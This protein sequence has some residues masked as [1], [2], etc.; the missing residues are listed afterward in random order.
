MSWQSYESQYCLPFTHTH[1]RYIKCHF[2]ERT[3]FCI[4]S[5]VAWHET[6]PHSGKI[7][8][9]C[10]IYETKRGYELSCVLNFTEKDVNQDIIFP[11]SWCFF[12]FISFMLTLLPLSLELEAYMRWCNP[13]VNMCVCSSVVLVFSCMLTTMMNI[14]WIRREIF[15]D[16]KMYGTEI[17]KIKW[18][19]T[20]MR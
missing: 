13:F 12:V 5:E 9:K 7:Y 15:C 16:K 6:A 14:H 10:D 8:I 4:D 18:N 17:K 19:E 20:K 1:T 2:I 11:R 3:Y